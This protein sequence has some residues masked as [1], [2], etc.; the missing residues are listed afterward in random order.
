MTHNHR[1]ARDIRSALPT[2]QGKWIMRNA[3][4]LMAAL[5]AIAFVT[6]QGCSSPPAPSP[7]P[8]PHPTHA[9]KLKISVE[10][11]SVVNRVEVESIWVVG[12]LSCAPVAWPSGST[13]VKQVHVPE[14]VEKVGDDYIAT[15]V[16]DRFLPDRCHWLGGGYGIRF[17][18]DKS[19]LGVS[20]GSLETLHESGGKVEGVCVPP[21]APG[22]PPIC[23]SR[24][25]KHDQFLRSHF[26]TLF[27]EDEELVP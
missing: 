24:N 26:K 9:R 15:L 19:L 2:A 18:H 11:G 23:F 27:N 21:S 7:T 12:D 3:Q 4:R 8:N 20:G 17:Y 22:D 10:R 13:I 6:L 1:C 25:A 5:A 14:A 16:L